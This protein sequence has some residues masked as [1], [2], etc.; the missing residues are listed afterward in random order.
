MKRK[1][2]LVSGSFNVLH[3]GH[4]RLLRF[5]KSCGDYLI[6]AVNSDRLAASEASVRQ[7]LRLEVIASNSVDP[8]MLIL[9]GDPWRG[10]MR[11]RGL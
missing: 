2:V 11:S 10:R 4:L 8:G 3:P 7:N 1:T 6:V 5:A 9:D